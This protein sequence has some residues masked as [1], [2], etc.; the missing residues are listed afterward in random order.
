MTLSF[1]KHD[2][3]LHI[4]HQPH[5]ANYETIE[6]WEAFAGGRDGLWVSP[7]ARAQAIATDSLWTVQWYP[8]TPVGFHLLAGSDLGPVLERACEISPLAPS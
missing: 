2:G 4:V 6:E 7:E 1:P 5:K 8:E 3:G